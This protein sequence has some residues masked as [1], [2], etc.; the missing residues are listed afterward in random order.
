MA[1]YTFSKQLTKN[2][3][4]ELTIKVGKDRFLAEKAKIFKKL[5]AEVT[6]P[7]FRPG[8]GPENLVEARLGTRL[9]EE[10][11]NHL[12]PEITLDVLQSEKL[13]PLTQIKYSLLKATNEEGV[14]FKATFVELPKI[15]LGDF[16]RIKPKSEEI[17][18][19]EAEIDKT[20]NQ[21]IEINRKRKQKPV[22]G[23]D[24]D[25][26]KKTEKNEP[27]APTDA[28]VKEL[29]LGFDTVAKLREEL[30]KRIEQEKKLD[31]ESRK[32][33]QIIA[34]AVKLSGIKVPGALVDAEV[35]KREHDYTHK[36]EDLGLKLEDFL[37]SQNTTLDEQRKKWR[38]EAAKR[39][40]TELL[41][42]EIARANEIKI[43]DSEIDNEIK[44]IRDEKLKKEYDSDMGKRYI[45][46]VLLQQK[47]IKWLREQIEQK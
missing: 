23:K 25:K 13:N 26:A 14:E 43:T 35:A 7:G 4:T 8:K 9:M 11:I 16:K 33:E 44:L 39:L 21:L 15:K 30:K 42:I 22:E 38:E 12:I 18:V 10:T 31:M 20:L 40:Q 46:S 36:V 6:M 29:G 19:T 17:A 32:L 41:L 34:E 24:A 5:S 2:D 28:E 37:K 45:S 3:E 1:D 47:A 27:N